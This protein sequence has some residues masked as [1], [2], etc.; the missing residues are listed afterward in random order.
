MT[1]LFG[2]SRNEIL[3]QWRYFHQSDSIFPRAQ[4]DNQRNRRWRYFPNGTPK[5]SLLVRNAVSTGEWRYFSGSDS[6]S[7]KYCR[8]RNTVAKKILSWQYFKWRYF[9]VTVFFRDGTFSWHSKP[10]PKIDHA[11]RYYTNGT[12]TQ[13]NREREG[14]GRGP[15]RVCK[16]NVYSSLGAWH[17]DGGGLALKGHLKGALKVTLNCN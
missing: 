2:V 10:I 3:S 15:W 8:L 13:A 1:A 9:P 12:R 14:S 7:W 16:Y 4:Y 5:H 11:W 17:A 6:I